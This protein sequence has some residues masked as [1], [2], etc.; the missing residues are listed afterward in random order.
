MSSDNNNKKC[1]L[2]VIVRVKFSYHSVPKT[3]LR[4]ARADLFVFVDHHSRNGSKE[5]SVQEGKFKNSV[6][7]DYES[8]SWSSDDW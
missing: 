7:S 2:I 3:Y 4:S 6:Q 1:N 8:K 5:L